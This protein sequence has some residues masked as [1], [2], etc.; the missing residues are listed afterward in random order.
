MT[1]TGGGGG[2]RSR[3]GALLVQ[4]TWGDGGTLARGGDSAASFDPMRRF[5]ARKACRETSFLSLAWHLT[6]FVCK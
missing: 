6:F 4:T 2:A 5:A 3:V 1:S